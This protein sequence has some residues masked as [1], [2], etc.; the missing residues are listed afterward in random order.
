V[1]WN[2]GPV[3]TITIQSV[4]SSTA[5]GGFNDLVGVVLL[6]AVWHGAGQPGL[7]TVRGD[8]LVLGMA[9]N[10]GGYL[11]LVPC[12]PSD[13]IHWLVRAAQRRLAPVRT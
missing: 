7:S 1:R 9:P 12:F 11:N 6:I 5:A 13:G 4:V 8:L 2:S 10:F 3:G